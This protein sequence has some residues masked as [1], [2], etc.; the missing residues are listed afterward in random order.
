MFDRYGVPCIRVGL[1]AS[2]NLRDASLAI[3]GA[4]HSAIG[5]MAMSALYYERICAEL[6][7]LKVKGGSLIIYVASGATS[8]AIGQKKKNKEKIYTKYCLESLKVLEKNENI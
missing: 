1:C 3:A 6:D 5:E 7:K 4:T 2:E 8:K